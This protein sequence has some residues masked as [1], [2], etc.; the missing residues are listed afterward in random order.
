MYTCGNSG[1]GGKKFAVAKRVISDAEPKSNKNVNV[2]AITFLCIIFHRGLLVWFYKFCLLF[3]I[4]TVY[5]SRLQF[6]L[7]YI[8]FNFDVME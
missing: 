7:F 2:K 1:G 3:K 4:K 8:L 6:N 5:A